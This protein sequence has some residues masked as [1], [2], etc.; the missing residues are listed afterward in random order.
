[1][2]VYAPFY[3]GEIQGEAVSISAVPLKNWKGKHLP[4]FAPTPELLKW[5]KASTQDAEAE[6]RVR[7]LVSAGSSGAAA[8]D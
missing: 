3:R 4:L 5:G 8:V 6:K 7:A 2:T 1:M